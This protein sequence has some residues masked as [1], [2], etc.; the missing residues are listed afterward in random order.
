MIRFDW[1]N[2]KKA[3]KNISYGTILQMADIE[4]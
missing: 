1:V 4:W 2:G 3:S